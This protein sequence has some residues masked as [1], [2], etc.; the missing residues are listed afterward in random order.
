MHSTSV[1]RTGRSW[2]IRTLKNFLHNLDHPV[3]ILPLCLHFLLEKVIKIIQ[4]FK[5]FLLE[6]LISVIE[7]YTNKLQNFS[8][9]R[10]KNILHLTIHNLCLIC[11]LFG[12]YGWYNYDSKNSRFSLN[13][14]ILKEKKSLCIK[15]ISYQ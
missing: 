3:C 2:R 13:P 5:T 7:I 4:I 1:G 11:N 15:N 6:I 12:K 8:T 14:S 10:K 9:G